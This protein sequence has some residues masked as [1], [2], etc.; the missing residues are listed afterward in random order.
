MQSD[1]SATLLIASK[2]W[3]KS[4]HATGGTRIGAAE[5]VGELST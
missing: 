3:G 2:L 4:N 1:D 5:T